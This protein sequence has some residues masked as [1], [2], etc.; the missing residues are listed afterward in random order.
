[1]LAGGIRG[2][3]MAEFTKR[4]EVGYMDEDPASGNPEIC[5]EIRAA[6]AGRKVGK[7]IP[8]RDVQ[9]IGK[10]TE[11]ERKWVAFLHKGD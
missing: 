3:N 8:S 9:A 11:F 10:E 5:R 1:V 2:K 7:P 4:S 6:L